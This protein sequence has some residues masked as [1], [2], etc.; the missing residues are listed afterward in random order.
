LSSHHIIRD[1]QE[2]PI[3]VFD[4]YNNWQELTELLGWSPLLLIAPKLQDIFETKQINIDGYLIAEESKEDASDQ[5]LVYDEKQPMTGLLNWIADQ[6]CTAL[7]CFCKVDLMKKMFFKQLNQSLAIPFIFFTEE[8][9]Y[10]LK[11]SNEFKKWYP[12]GFRLFVLNEN[13]IEVQNLEAVKDGFKVV[14]NGFVYLKA[15][16]DKILLGE[17]RV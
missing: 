3:L 2:P 15:K 7:N 11:P 17:A 10:I 14:Q 9:K 1:E 8:G 13:L 6:D 16:G 5:D 12:K 4:V